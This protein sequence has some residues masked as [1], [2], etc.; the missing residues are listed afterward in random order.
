MIWGNW[1]KNLRLRASV[2]SN[3]TGRGVWQTNIQLGCRVIAARPNQSPSRRDCASG[4]SALAGIHVYAARHG[5]RFRHTFRSRDQSR[6]EMPMGNISGTWSGTCGSMCPTTHSKLLTT[7]DLRN[8][9]P[10]FAL[11]LL[12]TSPNSQHTPSPTHRPTDPPPTPA[13]PPPPPQ[14][15]PPS[16]SRSSP[17]PYPPPP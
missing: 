11:R 7:P 17:G 4:D 16:S 15:P 1:G 14:N 13:A 12:T 5:T 6:F 9:E 10:H 3:N 8:P 2:R